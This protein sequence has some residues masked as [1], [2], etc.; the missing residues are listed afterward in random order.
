MSLLN[1]NSKLTQ[2]LQ[3]NGF[4]WMYNK[5]MNVYYRLLK[6]TEQ[7]VSKPQAVASNILHTEYAE[8]LAWGNNGRIRK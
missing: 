7:P 6:Q 4:D 3:E 8:M 5:G 1:V 2:Q